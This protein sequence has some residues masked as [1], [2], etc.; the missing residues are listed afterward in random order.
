MSKIRLSA[1]EVRWCKF[2]AVLDSLAYWD[3]SVGS[4]CAAYEAM[5]KCKTN[6]AM[7][8]F[9]AKWRIIWADG[10]RDVYLPT[11]RRSVID[12]CSTYQAAM[13]FAIKTR[14]KKGIK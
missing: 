4:G 13:R 12:K 11:V 9:E 6:E 2:Q 14:T 5:V 3:P 10:L 8:E 1:E 7:L